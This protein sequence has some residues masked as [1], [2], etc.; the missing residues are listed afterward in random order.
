M[1]VVLAILSLGLLGVIIY[2]AISPKSSR[3]LKL[4]ALIAL[5]VIGLSLM[6]CAILIIIGPKGD[7]ETIPLVLQDVA[8]QVKR[9]KNILDIIIIIG[10]LLVV[11]LVI[12]KSMRDQKKSG[13][14]LKKPEKPKLFQDGDDLV[15]NVKL[16]NAEEDNDED[17]ESFD[18]STD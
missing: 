7:K 11:S 3:L 4:T 2:F 1:V 14:T 6:V 5:G 10:L 16:D 18:L 17:E 13:L 8:P 15:L 9:D 12:F